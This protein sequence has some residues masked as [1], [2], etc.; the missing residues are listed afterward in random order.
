MKYSQGK[1]PI[2]TL[3]VW[4]AVYHKKPVILCRFKLYLGEEGRAMMVWPGQCGILPDTTDPR[5][6]PS[7]YTFLSQF[8]LF[9]ERKTNLGLAIISRSGSD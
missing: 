9:P 8:Q 4:M 7:V 1:K 2:K 3:D 5:I 6:S